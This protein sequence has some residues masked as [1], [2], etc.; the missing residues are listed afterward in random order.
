MWSSLPQSAAGKVCLEGSSTLLNL[1]WTWT[2]CTMWVWS[3][4]KIK[5][6]GITA[7]QDSRIKTWFFL[8]LDRLC[9]SSRRGLVVSLCQSS[10]SSTTGS[11]TL[12][13]GSTWTLGTE[14]GLGFFFCYSCA[15]SSLSWPPLTHRKGKHY[16]PFAPKF[17]R[18]QEVTFGL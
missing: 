5:V 3:D 4:K 7:G 10:T 11:W 18:V 17:P 13:R 2:I 15:L 16:N 6:W 1:D 8:L 14:M 12:S 9:N